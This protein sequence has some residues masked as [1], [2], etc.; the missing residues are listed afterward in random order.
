MIGLPGDRIELT[1]G[2][3]LVN[4]TAIDEPYI[5][6]EGGR[7][8]RTDPTAGGLSE[9]LVPAGDLFVLGDHREDSSDSR[10]FGP[11]EINHVL[12]RAWL[13]YWPVNA[14]GILHGAA[15]SS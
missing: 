11:V 14:F 2:K 6:A 1:N 4:G 8:Q 3:V 15:A 7:K 13:R 9:W 5:Y 10:V 12:G